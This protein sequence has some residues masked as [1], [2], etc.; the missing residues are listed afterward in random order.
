MPTSRLNYIGDCFSDRILLVLEIS[1]NTDALA[2]QIDI[3][4]P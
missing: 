3:I 4:L 1:D 2:N